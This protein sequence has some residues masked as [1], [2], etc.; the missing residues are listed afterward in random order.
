MSILRSQEDLLDRWVT[1]TVL[2]SKISWI[3]FQI[4]KQLHSDK[5][6]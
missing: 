3:L 5:Y 2:D 1:D 4:T 6:E